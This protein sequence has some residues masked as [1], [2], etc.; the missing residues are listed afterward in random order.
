[1]HCLGCG[2]KG[3]GFRVGDFGFWDVGFRGL[4]LGLC[5]LGFRDSGLGIGVQGLEFG[6]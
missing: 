5:S 6:I 4:V 2:V 1:M 3:L